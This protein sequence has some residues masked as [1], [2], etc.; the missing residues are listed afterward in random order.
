MNTIGELLAIFAELQVRFVDERSGLEGVVRP[1]MTEVPGGDAAQFAIERRR[2][3]VQDGLIPAA[4]PFQK[5]GH[6]RVHDLLY[7][8]SQTTSSLMG[9]VP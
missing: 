3:L 9:E 4:E 8:T 6:G 7:N 2:E 5:L 1:L